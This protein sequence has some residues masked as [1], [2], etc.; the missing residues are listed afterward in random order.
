MSL[1]SAAWSLDAE[2]TS[3]R[4]SWWLTEARYCVHVAPDCGMWWHHRQ[5]HV[6]RCDTACE[7]LQPLPTGMLSTVTPCSHPSQSCTALTWQPPTRGRS[8]IEAPVQPLTGRSTANY[9]MFDAAICSDK[10]LGFADNR[11]AELVAAQAQGP[12]V[13]RPH[14]GDRTWC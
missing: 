14:S 2:A 1:R 4:G 12:A 3:G 10:V 13:S 9:S 7:Q 11:Y 5:R 6:R 8:Q